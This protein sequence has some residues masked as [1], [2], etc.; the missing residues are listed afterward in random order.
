MKSR[1][2]TS[3]Q[4]IRYC[5]RLARISC[6]LGAVSTSDQMVGTSSLVATQHT[7]RR[8]SH[9]SVDILPDEVGGAVVGAVVLAIPVV[10][11]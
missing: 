10:A 11:A 7:I 3:I 4:D 9:L 2:H 8:W 5:T 6:L 1:Q